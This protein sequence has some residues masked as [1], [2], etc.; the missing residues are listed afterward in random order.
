MPCRCRGDCGG[1]GDDFRLRVETFPSRPVDGGDGVST[2]VISLCFSSQ[3]LRA[4]YYRLMM[5]VVNVK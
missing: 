4:R 1:E 5:A 2:M 3:S